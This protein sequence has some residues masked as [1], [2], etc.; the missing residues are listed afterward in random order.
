[1][2]AE[3]NGGTPNSTGRL[4][5]VGRALSLCAAYATTTIAVSL[6]IGVGFFV[7]HAV[8]EAQ[9]PREIPLHMEDALLYLQVIAAVLGMAAAFAWVGAFLR[10]IDRQGR[11]ADLRLT[12]KP[13]A[14]RRLGIGIVAAALLAGLVLGGA[15]LTGQLR[16]AGFHWQAEGGTDTLVDLV[17]YSLILLATILGEELV[18]RGY[19]RWTLQRA[20]KPG[21]AVLGSALAFALM[22][23]FAPHATLLAFLNSLLAGI[24]LSLLAAWAGSL[25]ATI[26]A[27]LTWALLVGY[28]FSLPLAASPIEGLVATLVHPGFAMDARFG[29]EGSALL[30]C[31]LAVILL[32]L[33]VARGRPSLDAL[34]RLG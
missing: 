32:V 13:G 1:M 4:R 20:F 10:W 8:F 26:A 31:L 27:R 2:N 25:W 16:A 12:W 11:L 15:Y 5:A 24:L 33:W 34:E 6:P 28:V 19:A 14:G 30:L 17:G 9:E 21:Y 29:P 3:V 23:A 22:R 7:Y 18:F